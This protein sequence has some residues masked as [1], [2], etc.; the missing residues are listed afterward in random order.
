MDS[1]KVTVTT[2]IV[3]VTGVSLDLNTLELE[4]AGTGTLVAT[5]APA[6]ASDNS[7]TWSTADAGVA[8]VDNGTVTGVAEGE[9]YVYVTTNDGGFMDS[10]MVTVTGTA[11]NDVKAREYKL[12]PN[13]VSNGMLFIQLA[14]N[15]LV[16]S[17]EI[18]NTIG[19]LVHREAVNSRN[20]IELNTSAMLEKG[21]YFVKFT[22]PSS[23]YIE[24]IMVQ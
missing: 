9:A 10:C 6:D 14:E 13:P 4:P 17:I 21:I 24:R 3:N 18:Y 20:L 16:S 8:T 12:Y 22:Q 15:S 1:C 7:V 11:V 19:V 23:T 2:S 5:V